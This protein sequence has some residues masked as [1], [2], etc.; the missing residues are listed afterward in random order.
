MVETLD[1]MGNLGYI[2]PGSGL[3]DAVELADSLQLYRACG[4]EEHQ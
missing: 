3:L 2:L 1:F 4:H